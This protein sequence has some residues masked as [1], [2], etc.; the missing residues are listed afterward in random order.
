MGLDRG[1]PLQTANQH[2]GAGIEV[3]TQETPGN[4]TS[5]LTSSRWVTPG[6]SWKEWPRTE[7]SGDLWF[8]PMSA[9]VQKPCVYDPKFLCCLDFNIAWI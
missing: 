2:K 1:H 7:N 6:T 3:A 9:S 8:I 4:M 5:R